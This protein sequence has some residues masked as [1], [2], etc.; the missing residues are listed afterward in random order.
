[1]AP[2][3]IPRA[4]RTD[5]CPGFV[6]LS[7]FSIVLHYGEATASCSLAKGKIRFTSRR[8][9][10]ANV[11]ITG[12]GAV[13]YLANSERLLG[14][15]NSPFYWGR[16]TY[17]TI[18]LR[19]RML[20][21]ESAPV[22]P[23]SFMPGFTYQLLGLKKNSPARASMVIINIVPFAH[24]SNGQSGCTL[25]EHSRSREGACL[26]DPGYEETT[27]HRLNVDT[28]SF[29]THYAAFSSYYR[30]IHLAPRYQDG[31]VDTNGRGSI[32]RHMA[33]CCLAW[34][35]VRR[36][37]TNAMDRCGHEGCSLRC[38]TTGDGLTD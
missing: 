37:V 10:Q 14:A 36:A 27:R 29:S 8:R 21:A 2:L 18:M 34:R 15:E 1:M 32:Q 9:S 23:P 28:G 19:L 35:I 4:T 11:P 6:Y 17:A 24:H 30:S 26:P 13:N 16:Q 3:A 12:H 31:Q 38:G 5:M 33:A 25:L 22:P 7:L 20:D